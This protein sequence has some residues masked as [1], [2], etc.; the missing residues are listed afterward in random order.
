[1]DPLRVASVGLGWWGGNLAD[2]A[3]L[4]G[5]Q[6]VSCFAR[7]PHARQEFAESHDCRAAASLDELLSDP[8][9][10]AVFW[11]LRTRLTPTSLLR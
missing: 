2:K 9:V 3:R 7:T 11:P 8:D 1:M 6:V 10:E 5:L 4:G